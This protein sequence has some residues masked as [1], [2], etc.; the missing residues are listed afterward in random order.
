MQRAI[1]LFAAI[2]ALVTSHAG[3]AQEQP[4][5]SG[6]LFLYSEMWAL[7]GVCNQ[8]AGYDVE[9][10]ELAAFLNDQ[11][12]D[13]EVEVWLSVAESRTER[14]AAIRDEIARIQSLP[15]G[16]RRQQAVDENAA[17]LMSRCTRL[18]NNETAGEFF[19]RAS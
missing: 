4:P 19:R 5:T 2:M 8:L 3:K 6:D 14:L 16:N 12:D 13:L 9:Q 17:S 10:E 7:A 18:A 15:N 1:F 11:R